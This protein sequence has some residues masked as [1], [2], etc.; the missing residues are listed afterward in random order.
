MNGGDSS[1]AGQMHNSQN[2][3]VSNKDP[4]MEAL[5]DWFIDNWD[6]L[7]K[8]PNDKAA[9]KNSGPNAHKK[10]KEHKASRNHKL[11]KSRRQKT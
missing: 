6:M 1:L 10:S 8:D 9:G 5:L 4:R 2:K 3:V 7:T 11:S